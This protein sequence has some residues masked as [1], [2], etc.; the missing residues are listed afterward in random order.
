MAIA[1]YVDEHVATAIVEGLVDRGCDV[2]RVQDDG[3]RTKNDRWILDRAHDLG[4]VIFTMDEDFLVLASA[5]QKSG[6]LFSGIIYVHQLRYSIG[7]I[8][9]RLSRTCREESADT[10]MNRVKYL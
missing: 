9:D 2:L 3:G 6:S 5:C 1:L 4:R 7:Q 10:F 8:V